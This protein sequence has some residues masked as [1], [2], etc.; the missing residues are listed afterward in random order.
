ML[1]FFCKKKKLGHAINIGLK[2]CHDYKL[3]IYL[4]MSF[5]LQVFNYELFN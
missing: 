4:I 3:I 1:T 2:K 5:F